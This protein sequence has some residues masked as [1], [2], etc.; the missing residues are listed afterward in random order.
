MPRE[1]FAKHI[2]YLKLANFK[3]VIEVKD[4]VRSQ[5]ESENEKLVK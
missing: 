1:D 4:E 2:C 3:E 5:A